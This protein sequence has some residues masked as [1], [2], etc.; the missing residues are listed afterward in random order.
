MKNFWSD[1]KLAAT[2]P[3]LF[4]CNGAS[5][6]DN[7]DGCKLDDTCIE[8][9]SGPLCESCSPGMA[10]WS[11]ECFDCDRPNI[12]YFAILIITVL[13]VA[14]FFMFVSPGENI[15]LFNTFFTY[16]VMDLVFPLNDIQNMITGIASMSPS[17]VINFVSNNFTKCLAPFRGPVI[18]ITAVIFYFCAFF[19]RN[20]V[21][22]GNSFILKLHSYLPSRLQNKTMESFNASLLEI[23]L[24]VFE[25]LFENAISV[26]D[27]RLIS[28]EGENVR[29]LDSY[30]D[31]ICYHGSHI[32]LIILAVILLSL[33]ILFP[34]FLMRLIYKSRISDI[35]MLQEE[36]EIKE[37]KKI[38]NS[39]NSIESLHFIHVIIREY[40]PQY[41]YWISADLVIK[42]TLVTVSVLSSYLGDL[43]HAHSMFFT[44]IIYVVLVKNNFYKRD[45][46]NN[47]NIL[48]SSSLLGVAGIGIL[49]TSHCRFENIVCDNGKEIKIC[50][51]QLTLF[52]VGKIAGFSRLTVWQHIFTFMPLT[53][54]GC[55]ILINCWNFLCQKI[56]QKKKRKLMNRIDVENNIE[57]KR[58]KLDTELV[59][60]VNDESSSS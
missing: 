54:L 39:N 8:N 40:K 48:F 7:T 51:L 11:A 50:Q 53:V 19:W 2:R 14:F 1:S 26:F 52:F 16:Q 21:K 41:P 5:C 12:T 35:K 10:R 47:C 6:C 23:L 4:H 57:E 60:D 42:M 25:P 30:P 34:F 13:F 18:V 45:I 9:S 33:M 22:K 37:G 29:V 27:C 17:V 58:G 24:F 32:P 20:E 3:R 31:V 55:R 49:Q 28:L 44:L 38:R 15:I 46:E 56:S 36:E 59:V 43:V